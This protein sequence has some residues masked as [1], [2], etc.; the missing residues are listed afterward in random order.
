MSAHPSSRRLAVARSFLAAAEARL[1]AGPD[2]ADLGPRAFYDEDDRITA[3]SRRERHRAALEPLLHACREEVRIAEGLLE[4]PWQ[5]EPDRRFYASARRGSQTVLLAGPF[6][7]HAEAL[8]VLPRARAFV[9]RHY[10]GTDFGTGFGTC[11]SLNPDVG[12][13]VAAV[14]AY[15]TGQHDDIDRRPVA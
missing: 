5:P 13:V 7:T 15:A 8:R 3:A 6:A 4:S 14:H 1:C 11:S 12:A 9:W 2:L 10:S